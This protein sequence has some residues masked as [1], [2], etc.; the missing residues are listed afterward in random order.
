ME[1]RNVGEIY[2]SLFCPLV[3]P[4]AFQNPIKLKAAVLID[5]R[6]K[7]VKVQVPTL[8]SCAMLGDR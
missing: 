6:K 7:S 5:R 4:P 1:R 3:N 8:L 2:F